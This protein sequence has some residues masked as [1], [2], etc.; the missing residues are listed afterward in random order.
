MIQILMS[1]SLVEVTKRKWATGTLF[2]LPTF[3]ILNDDTAL[4]R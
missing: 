4:A 1:H 3:E 2:M